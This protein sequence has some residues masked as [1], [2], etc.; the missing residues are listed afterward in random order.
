MKLKKYLIILSAYLM[1]IAVIICAGL[2]INQGITVF[3]ESTPPEH[4]YTFVI[5]AGHGGIDGGATS[6]SGFLESK[7]N[8]DI[9]LRLNDLMHLLGLH[10]VMIRTE[11]RSIHTEGETIAAQKLSDLKNRLSIIKSADHPVLISIHQNHFTDSRYSGAQVFYASTENSDILAKKMQSALIEALNP[12]SR[13]QVKKAESVYIMK[14]IT[15]PGILI[16]CGFI[17][18]L[19]EDALL[20]SANYQQKICAVIAT[21]LCQYQSIT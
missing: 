9:A 1:V 12:Q 10:T 6:I 18:N 5:D 11:D 8:L 13:R 7:Y 16:E 2:H 21:Q 15:C 20:R 14:H 17:S 19:Q 3:S 4:S